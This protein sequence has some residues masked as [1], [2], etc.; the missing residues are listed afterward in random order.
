MEREFLTGI[1]FNLYVDQDT[2][3]S[4]RDLLKGLVMAKERDR[5]QWRRSS[6]IQHRSSTRPSN[7]SSAAPVSRSYSL[8]YR[9]PSHRARSTSPG[10]SSR[11]FTYA[12]A[13]TAPSYPSSN[14]I[15]LPAEEYSPSPKPGSKR[16][17][18]EAFSPT[19]A[20]PADPRPLKR[21]TSMSLEIPDFT[22]GRNSNPSSNSVSPLESL[23][24]L[25]RMS[26]GSSPG[27]SYAPQTN[28]P[29]PAWISYTRSDAAPQTLVAAYRVEKPMEMPQVRIV[30][31]F[32]ISTPAKFL[33]QNLYYYSLAGSATKDEESLRRKAKLRCHQPP[34]P[35][36][37]TYYPPQRVIPMN[38]QSASTSPHGLHMNVGLAPSLP[39]FHDT[40][41]TRP[42]NADGSLAYD[43]PISQQQ[44]QYTSLSESPVPTAPFANAGP[45]GFQ[46][47]TTPAQISPSPLY[48][49]N[50][51]TRGRRL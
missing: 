18:A 31:Y 15:V 10:E 5:Q 25:S 19:L 39:H 32:E 51:S 12:F 24:S 23:Q 26:L 9:G 37:A 27:A 36:Y 33:F 21:P 4:W 20:V 8:R 6:R 17:A 48:A 28:Q 1:D 13:F 46:F 11:S 16:H 40:A 45:P 49:Y 47:Y 29:S 44:Q 14:S 2:Y 34:P 43:Y 35:T 30:I 3:Q 42:N 38:V 22:P 41:W 7:T 50:W